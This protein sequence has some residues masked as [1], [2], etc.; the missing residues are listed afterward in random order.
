M[1]DKTAMVHWEGRGKK[2]V[3]KI[4]TETDAI[5]SYPYGL[6]SRFEDDRRG[7]NPEELLAAAH[8]ACF[9]MAFSFACD[10]AGF[11]TTAI[12]TQASVRLVA[13]GGG[14]VIDHIALKLEAS[15]PGID[16]PTFQKLAAGA[17]KDCPLSQGAGQ[18]AGDY[19]HRGAQE[20]IASLVLAAISP[21]TVVVKV[22]ANA[23]R[24]AN[25]SPPLPSKEQT[26]EGRM[27]R[28]HVHVGVDDLDESVR[29]YS[30][31]F[32]VFRSSRSIA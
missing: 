26:S 14:F 21:R 8:A 10:T 17:K 25:R 22:I 1:T 2:G 5:K 3:G 32:R 24:R 18:C 19:A 31:L 16:E 29:F 11:A 9:T 15:V 28:F 7:T 13:K 12:D 20:L 23:R 30:T 4:S 27:K 6:G